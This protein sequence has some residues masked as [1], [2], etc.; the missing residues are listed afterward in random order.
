MQTKSLCVR[1]KLTIAIAHSCLLLHVYIIAVT[2]PVDDF[3]PPTQSTTVKRPCHMAQ[4]SVWS[5]VKKV[6][7]L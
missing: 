1:I 7:I 6:L 3:A 5:C 4:Y 2:Q